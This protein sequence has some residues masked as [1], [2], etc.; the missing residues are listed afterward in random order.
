MKE[1]KEHWAFPDPG[2]LGTLVKW[3]I[4]AAVVGV[5]AYLALTGDAGAEGC[6][7]TLTGCY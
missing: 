5:L 4:V 2:R 1:S 3:L 7:E 6:M